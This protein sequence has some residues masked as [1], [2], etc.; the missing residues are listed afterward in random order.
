M[1]EIQLE[2]WVTF[3]RTTLDTPARQAAVAALQ[4]HGAVLLA[5]A[6]AITLDEDEAQDLVQAT[7]EIALRQL[8]DLREPA[9]LRAWLLRIETREAFRVVR[10]LRRLVRLDGHVMELRAP[11]TD[12]AQQADIRESLAALPARIRA[13]IALHYLG[14]LTVRETA[15]SLGVSENTIKSELKTGLVKLREGLRE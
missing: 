1:L 8:K 12:L 9:S 14:G 15:A 6:R 7:F 11:G 2:T 13:A 5:A 4:E 3:E 10:R